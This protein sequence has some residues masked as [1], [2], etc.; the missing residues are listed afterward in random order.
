MKK[1]KFGIIVVAGIILLGAGAAGAQ[2]FKAK[3]TGEAEATPVDTSTSGKAKVRF[4][5]DVVKFWIKLRRAEGITQ[6]HIHCAPGGWTGR[7]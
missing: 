4:K 2:T 6:A 3:L 1:A 5:G 7:L